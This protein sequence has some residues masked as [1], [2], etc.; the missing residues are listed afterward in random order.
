MNTLPLVL[1]LALLTGCT[2]T[3]PYDPVERITCQ[4]KD[5]MGEKNGWRR[6]VEWSETEAGQAE[7]KLKKEEQQAWDEEH[8]EEV[9]RQDAQR[10]RAMEQYLRNQYT[11]AYGCPGTSTPAYWS[12]SMG[13]YACGYRP[14]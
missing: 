6:H 12:R 9:A 10:R 8:P 5:C 13:P 3:I 1:S 11:N 2:K 14:Y 7:A 4:G